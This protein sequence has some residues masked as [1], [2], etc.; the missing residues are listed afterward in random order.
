MP[1]QQQGQRAMPPGLVVLVLQVTLLRWAYCGIGIKLS[2]QRGQQQSAR[3]QA[4]GS[5]RLR[6]GRLLSATA[7]LKDLETDEGI[8]VCEQRLFCYLDG[9]LHGAQAGTVHESTQGPGKA[10][11]AQ[12]SCTSQHDCR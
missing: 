1:L 8:A 5:R 10:S 6:E 11:F 7:P 2:T 3:Q 9:I 4:A 12:A